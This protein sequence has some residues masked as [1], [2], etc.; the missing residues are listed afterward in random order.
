MHLREHLRCVGEF[1]SLM[2]WVVGSFVRT[3]GDPST[4]PPAAGRDR[5]PGFPAGPGSAAPPAGLT[6]SGELPADALGGAGFT[7]PPRLTGLG[8][9][10]PGV[11]GDEL[12]QDVWM[13]GV[14]LAGRSSLTGIELAYRNRGGGPQWNGHWRQ[15]AGSRR[16]TADG[17]RF[18]CCLRAAR[19]GGWAGD[20]AEALVFEGAIRRCPARRPASSPGRHPRRRRRSRAAGSS[21]PAAPAGATRP[22]PGKPR[23]P[24]P[25]PGRADRLSPSC[26]P[27][28]RTTSS[29]RPVYTP[30]TARTGRPA[31]A[32]FPV[33]RCMHLRPPGRSAH[34]IVS[35]QLET[36]LEG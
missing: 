21:A 35:R 7:G 1:L 4:R 27:S 10:I 16:V 8:H 32:Q 30:P 19:Q 22:A 26:A 2:C 13:H 18:A 3:S 36:T 6:A 17:R 31:G 5:D 34:R 28:F 9:Q 25:A 33:P 15:R 20:L 12:P 14:L 11:L 29:L 24:R 23:H